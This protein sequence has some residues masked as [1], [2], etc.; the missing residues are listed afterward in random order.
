MKLH[1]LVYLGTEPLIHVISDTCVYLLFHVHVAAVKQVGDVW[2]HAALSNTGTPC[3]GTRW[4]KNPLEQQ[5]KKNLIRYSSSLV[6]Q[7]AAHL[8]LTYAVVVIIAVSQQYSD[9]AFK[10]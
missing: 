3:N 9:Q 1:F 4:Q 8:K 5:N 10:I 6:R 2:R 7:A